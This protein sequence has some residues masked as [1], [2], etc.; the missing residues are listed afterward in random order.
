[1]GA[2]VASV[3]R[4]SVQHIAG[5]V[6]WSFARISSA[7]LPKRNTQA[8]LAARQLAVRW[9]DGPE[10]PPQKD[11]FEH[12]QRQPS[13]D[14]LSVDSGDV[15]KRLAGAGNVLR[16]RYTYPYQMHGSVGASCAVADVKVG[17]GNHMVR[18]AIS[19]SDAQ[20]RGQATEPA[21]R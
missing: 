7:S 3:D 11:F 12:L 19:L 6:K 16:A 21:A 9:N 8:M 1:M 4:E 17:S 13:K 20:Y 2:T 18:N 14:T 15:E 5:L 10:L